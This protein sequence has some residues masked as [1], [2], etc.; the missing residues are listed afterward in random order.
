MN[1]NLVPIDKLKRIITQKGLKKYIND[2][3]YSNAKNKKYYVKTIDGRKVNF[4]YIKMADYLTHKDKIRRDR[5][6]A[7]FNKLYERFKDDYNSAIFWSY[8]IL[9]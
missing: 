2:V 8:Q 5:F 4:G 6:R 3:G 1:N 9:W 7:R